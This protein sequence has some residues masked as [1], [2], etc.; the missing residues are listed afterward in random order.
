MLML[1]KSISDLTLLHSAGFCNQFAEFD[2]TKAASFFAVSE[3][4]IYRWLKSGM[5]ESAR[6]HLEA[7][8]H[9]DFLPYEWRRRGLRVTNDGVYLPCGRLVVLEVLLFWQFIG[10]CVDWSKVPSLCYDKILR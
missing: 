2:A 3:R 7:L 6:V 8:F 1:T 5:P 10:P 9:G 4:T